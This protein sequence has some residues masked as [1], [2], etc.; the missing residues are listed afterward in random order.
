MR[1]GA[2]HLID[3]LRGKVTDKVTQFQHQQPV[4]LGIG[5]DLP[6]AQWRAV[7]RQLIALGHVRTEGEYNTLE[8]TDSAREV[9]RG[10]VQL[11]LKPCPTRRRKRKGRVARTAG[12]ASH[13]AKAKPP[14]LPLDDEARAQRFDALKAWRAEVAKEHNLPAYIVFHDA[15]LA[16]MARECP[17]SLDDLAGISGVG[18]KK[19]RGLRQRD[20]AR[21]GICRPLTGRPRTCAGEQIGTA[22]RARVGLGCTAARPELPMSRPTLSCSMLALCLMAS[23]P[24]QAQ[25]GP[26]DDTRARPRGPAPVPAGPAQRP[27]PDRRTAGPQ[28][29]PAGRPARCTRRSL[30]P[31]RPMTTTTGQAA[32]ATTATT[33]YGRPDGRYQAGRGAGPGHNFYR[34]D[35]LPWEYRQRTYVVEDWRGHRLS[36]PPRGY[37]WVQAGGDYVLVA[38][39]TGVILQLLLMGN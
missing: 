16:E 35:R 36:A 10:E 29:P 32:A 20:P 7:L 38:I 34:G 6:E 28:R 23:L 12:G 18:A 33:C 9:L 30:R 4:H 22:H 5:A 24:L 15:T 8:L 39:A 26:R 25:P 21:A 11:Q 19:A 27:R 2:G 1:F 13:R 31:L 3:V 17:A 14:P 37:H